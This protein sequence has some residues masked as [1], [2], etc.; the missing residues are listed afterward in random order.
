MQL[1][2]IARLGERADVSADG[3]Q[4]DAHLACEASETERAAVT[5][6]FQ[7]VGLARCELHVAFLAEAV[8]S[9]GFEA[10]LAG[11]LANSGRKTTISHRKPQAALTPPWSGRRLI[12]TAMSRGTPKVW[13]L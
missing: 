5:D 13:M 4:G 9:R 10:I 11:F 7:N 8:S 12:A 6:T 1:H 2:Q 3:F